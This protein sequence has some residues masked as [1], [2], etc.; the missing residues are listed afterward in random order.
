MIGYFARRR[1]EKAARA[2]QYAEAKSALEQSQ[3]R[4]TDVDPRREQIS[5]LV[6][7]L[8]SIQVENHFTERLRKAYGE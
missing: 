4:A 1:A 2:A 7:R 3:A 8:R 5:E 6:A